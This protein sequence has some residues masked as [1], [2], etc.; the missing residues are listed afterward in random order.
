MLNRLFE[1][2]WRGDLKVEL[3]PQD[4]KSTALVNHIQGVS[5]INYA[6]GLFYELRQGIARCS[7]AKMRER[8]TQA[9][10]AAA[11]NG[12]G[13]G[14][15]D[16]LREGIYHAVAL[17]AKEGHR[18]PYQWISDKL[19]TYQSFGFHQ[20]IAFEAI[21]GRRPTVWQE[22]DV[23]SAKAAV[24]FL[25]AIDRYIDILQARFARIEERWGI[26]HRAGMQLQKGQFQ[27][28][29]ADWNLLGSLLWSISRTVFD[30]QAYMWLSASGVDARFN[31]ASS[32]LG[33]ETTVLG[34]VRRIDALSGRMLKG[35]AA[36]GHLKEAMELLCVLGTF[37]ARSFGMIPGARVWIS[38]TEAR[39]WNEV[40]LL[41]NIT[42]A[43]TLAEVRTGR[44]Y[45][46]GQVSKCSYPQFGNYRQSLSRSVLYT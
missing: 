23:V 9:L 10:E 15:C 13:R 4:V 40:R 1:A 12:P 11:T 17:K 42:Q 39:R 30:S 21:G 45:M 26:V 14:D 46:R 2:H 24:R 3:R 28:A 18:A 25:T 8:M 36:A 27:I 16:D 5:L 7:D 32:C 6:F 22:G 43:T 33:S 19:E 41:E 35:N 29:A 44:E 34:V 20:R 31:H 38:R 37:F